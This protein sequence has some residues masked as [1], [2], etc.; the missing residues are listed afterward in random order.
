MDKNIALILALSLTPSTILCF[1]CIIHLPFPVPFLVFH[2]LRTK[3][4]QSS[5]C[6]NAG[7]TAKEMR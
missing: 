2:I 3:R 6:A 5:Y 7:A 1:V 4:S